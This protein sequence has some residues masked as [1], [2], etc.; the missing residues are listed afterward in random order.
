MIKQTKKLSY[1]GICKRITEDEMKNARIRRVI[2]RKKE[3][4]ISAFES[5]I[6]RRKS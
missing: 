4:K 3:G 1:D 2:Q 5:G 6:S